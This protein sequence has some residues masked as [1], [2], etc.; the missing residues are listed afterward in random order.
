MRQ[1]EN[2]NADLNRIESPLKQ[3]DLAKTGVT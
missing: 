2:I 3:V 1:E